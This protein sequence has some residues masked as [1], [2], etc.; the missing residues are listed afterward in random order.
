MRRNIRGEVSARII[1]I[2]G[3]VVLVIAGAQYILLRGELSDRLDRFFN[4][5]CKECPENPQFE[6]PYFRSFR[7]HNATSAPLDEVTDVKI[8]VQKQ[9]PP[10][11]VWTEVPHSQFV[12]PPPL[13]IGPMQFWAPMNNDDPEFLYGVKVSV[14]IGASPTWKVAYVQNIGGR[15]DVEIDVVVEDYMW[16]DA[17]GTP[18]N[19]T[20]PRMWVWYDFGATIPSVQYDDSRTP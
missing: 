7:F 11:T 15:K 18:H 6:P 16:L 10:S 3:V 2:L 13:P 5:C 14:K 8:E 20:I 17:D 9:P 19:E 1:V 4:K 12:P